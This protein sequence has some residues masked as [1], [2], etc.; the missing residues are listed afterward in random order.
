[1]A[2]LKTKYMGLNLKN[3]II[4]ASSGLTGNIENIKKLEANGAGAV[5][6]KSIFEEEIMHEYNSMVKKI[7]KFS[8]EYEYFDYFDYKIKQENL[9]KYIKLISDA[10]KS[11]SIPVIASINCV[12]AHEWTYFAKKIEAAGAD[13]IELNLFVLPSDPNRSSAENEKIYFDVVEKIKTEVKIPVALKISHYFSNLAQTIQKLSESGIQGLALF[14]RFFSPDID[15]DEMKVV[16][17]NVLSAQS[18]Q[19]MPLRW[20]SIMSERVS[21]DLSATTGIHEG[22][23]VIKMLLVGAKAVQIA[24][25]VYKNGPETIQ[26]M[27]KELESW[28]DKHN[29]SNLDQ[30]IG[31]MS[32]SKDKNG[33]QYERVQ[34]M[35]YFGDK[36]SIL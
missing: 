2:D 12:S 1:M 29:Y 20:I 11:I 30:F 23:D 26:T 31:K 3:P 13:G 22:K 8:S 10:K 9:E 18:D 24:S 7:D 5:V 32:Q 21:C 16:N 27:L 33:A 15:V 4:V 35:R 28:M 6:L 25:T 36:E 17:S 34:F 14:N 19:V